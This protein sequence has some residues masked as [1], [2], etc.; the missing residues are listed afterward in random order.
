MKTFPFFRFLQID[1]RYLAAEAGLV[2]IMAK[3]LGVSCC[4]IVGLLASPGRS[5]ILCN[6]DKSI[7]QF[8]HIYFDIENKYFF[9]IWTNTFCKASWS[10][11]LQHCWAASWL[12]KNIVQSGQIYLSVQSNIFC[13]LNQYV[14]KFGQTHSAK[15]LE[16]SCCSC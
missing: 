2:I 13:N 11:L 14:L 3:V 5:K 10:Q 7:C 15:L 6:L 1:Q 12:V 8:N 16:L 4:S 9:E